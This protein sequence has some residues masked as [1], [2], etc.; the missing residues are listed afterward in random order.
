[1][2]PGREGDAST[3]N[4]KRQMCGLESVAGGDVVMVPGNLIPLEL[5]NE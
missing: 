5:V 4:E 3:I 1:M 2:G